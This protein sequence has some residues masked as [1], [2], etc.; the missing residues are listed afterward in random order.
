MLSLTTRPRLYWTL[1]V[2]AW[3][4]WALAGVVLSAVF[5]KFSGLLFAVEAIVGGRDAAQ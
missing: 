3:S 2:L 5:G 1:Q 4:L